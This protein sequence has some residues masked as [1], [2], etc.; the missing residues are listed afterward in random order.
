MLFLAIYKGPPNHFIYNQLG[1]GPT[2][3]G[4]WYEYFVKWFQKKQDVKEQ[5]K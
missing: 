1:L 5:R 4:A 3:P 2:P